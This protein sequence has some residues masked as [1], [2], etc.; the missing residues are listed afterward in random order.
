MSDPTVHDTRA[1]GTSAA[2]VPV[3]V[4]ALNF[5]RAESDTYFDGLAAHLGTRVWSHS[6]QPADVHHQTVIRMNRDT[7]YSSVVIDIS[8]GAQLVLPEAGG[9]YQTA[10]VVNQDHYVPRVFSSPGAHPLTIGELDTEFVVVVVRTLVDPTDPQD[11][12]AVAA[13]QDQVEITSGANRPF[14][15]PAWDPDSL[16][17]TRA[18][19]LKLAAATLGQGNA[20]GRRDEVDP[21]AHLLGTAAGWGGLPRQEAAYESVMPD[22]PVDHYT[23]RVGHVP[24]GAFWSVTVYNA[25]GFIEPNEHE[26]YSVN[27]VVAVPDPDGTVTINLGGDPELPN[28]IP[29][30]EGW[31]YAVRLYRPGPEIL[32]GSWRFPAIS[33]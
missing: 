17:A 26:H 13:L 8:Q 19:L 18:L 30:P 20:F 4:T 6:R 14:T 11:L 2:R 24:V 33:R 16:A 31:N 12:A 15:H 27:S 5:V 3:P 10:M 9:R 22:L 1:D 23:I 29:L 28:Q 32:D 21:I 25:D 7:L